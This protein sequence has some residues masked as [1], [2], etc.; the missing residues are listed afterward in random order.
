MKMISQ[1]IQAV[2][3]ARLK[4]SPQP[5]STF[6]SCSAEDAE[7]RPL[8]GPMILSFMILSSQPGQNPDRIMKDRIMKTGWS[9]LREFRRRWR[10]ISTIAVAEK[11]GGTFLS[12]CVLRASAVKLSRYETIIRD[13]DRV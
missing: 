4:D 9:A 8:G 5:M 13:T 7:K 2:V 3:A 11:V 12:L 10:T 1:G 6:D